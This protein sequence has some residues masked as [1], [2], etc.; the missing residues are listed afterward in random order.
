RSGRLHKL[1]GAGTRPRTCR[2]RCRRLRNGRSRAAVRRAWTD[3]G[4]AGRKPDVRAALRD[5][6]AAVMIRVLLLFAA[7]LALQAQQPT[8]KSGVDL[9]AVDGHVVDRQGRPVVDLKPEDFEVQI[10]GDRRKV[11]SAEL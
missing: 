8:F 4:T 3:H 1:R 7:A 5:R 9:V 10:A 6:E 11:A 2:P